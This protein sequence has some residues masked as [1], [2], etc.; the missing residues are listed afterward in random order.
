MQSD[1][2][3]EKRSALREPAAIPVHSGQ[4]RTE[5]SGKPTKWIDY[6]GERMPTRYILGRYRVTWGLLRGGVLSKHRS[7]RP[8]VELG[9]RAYPVRVLKKAVPCAN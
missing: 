4:V 7:K 1:S 9:G 2:T 3:T 6:Q 5:Y 8:T